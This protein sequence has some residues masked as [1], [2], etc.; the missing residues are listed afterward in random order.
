M[1]A[2][3][4]NDVIITR[5]GGELSIWFLGHASLRFGF[6]GKTI[7]VDPVGLF[8]DYAGAPG[9]D[10]ILVTHQHDDHLDSDLVGRLSKSTTEIISTFDVVAALGRGKAMKNGDRIMLGDWLVIDAVA[11]YNTTHGRDVFHP[12]GAYNGYVLTL[13]GTRIYVA[14]DTEPT[15]EMLALK[16]IDIA[17]LPVNQPY[18][19]TEEQAVEAVKK[20]HPSIFYPYHY[21]QTDHKT[22]LRKV[23]AGLAGTGIEVRIRAME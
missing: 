1:N 16:D 20:I 14:G 12:E 22:D 3:D 18:T 19:M 23:A 9:A 7:Y 21:G 11:A 4:Q 5:D 15:P 6:G 8:A 10:V 17:F 13:G 2:M